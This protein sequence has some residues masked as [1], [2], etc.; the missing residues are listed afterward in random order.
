MKLKKDYLMLTTL[1][2]TAARTQLYQLIDQAA[3][4]HYPIHIT[5]KRANAVLISEEDWSA[6]Q[7]TLYLISVPGM[8]ESLIKGR[9]IHISKCLKDLDW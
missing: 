9:K 6:I 3:H 7:E 8:R 4:S 5:G 2:A 1:T